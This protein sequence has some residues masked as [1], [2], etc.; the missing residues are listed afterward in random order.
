MRAG[1]QFHLGIVAGDLEAMM[2]ALSAVL[3][4]EW[5]PV[6]G[7]PNP[8]TLPGGE[9][10]LDI[11]CAYSVSVPRLEVIR[12][13]PGTLWEPDGIHHLGY[14]SDDVAGDGCELADKGFRVEASRTGPDGKPYFAFYRNDDGVRIELLSRAAEPGLSQCW[15][16]A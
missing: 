13:I 8:V 2:S 1:D 5:G 7:G 11:R 3:G 10:V 6:V 15:S 12:S 9:R 14:W 16:V 4:Y